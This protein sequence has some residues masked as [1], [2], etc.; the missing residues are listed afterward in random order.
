MAD[1]RLESY[2]DFV[3]SRL[4][5]ESQA[6]PLETAVYGLAGETG[7]FIDLQ[8][9]VKFQ[10]KA[11]DREKAIKELGDIMFYVAT[12]CIALDIP[13]KEVI[14]LNEEKLT[15]RYPNGFTVENSENRKKGDV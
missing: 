15:S 4:S 6:N 3:K 8:K 10:G 13:L 11:F 14:D 1:N 12:A 7:E 9:K 2:V 5:P